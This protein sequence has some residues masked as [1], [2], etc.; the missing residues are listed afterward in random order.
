[1]PSTLWL[2][3]LGP[4][5]HSV[6]D[7]YLHHCTELSCSNDGDLLAMGESGFT[8]WKVGG[9][10][11]LQYRGL[12]RACGQSRG[13]FAEP[14]RGP[15]R[16]FTTDSAGNFQEW[17]IQRPVGEK[18][19]KT[20][21]VPEFSEPVRASKPPKIEN[22]NIKEHTAAMAPPAPELTSGEWDWDLDFNGPE[23]G[24]SQFQ[25]E[26]SVNGPAEEISSLPMRD[27]D[28]LIGFY[29]S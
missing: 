14:P 10:S 3:P 18:T 6:V 4:P 9:R 13:A 22:R 8:L 1:M 19:S 2:Y 12:M 24:R 7:P 16:A 26:P 17:D 28:D 27:L 29:L 25:E 23:T 11:G 5:V 15:R 21:A 20:S